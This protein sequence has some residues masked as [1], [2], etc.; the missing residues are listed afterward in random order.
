[1]TKFWTILSGVSGALKKKEAEIVESST[2]LQEQL[3]ESFQLSQPNFIPHFDRLLDKETVSQALSEE[4][5]RVSQDI[6]VC[7]IQ[8]NEL[9]GRIK[10]D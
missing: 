1:M 3:S 4:F 8:K 9:N 6:L 10:I 7:Y 2:C 5:A